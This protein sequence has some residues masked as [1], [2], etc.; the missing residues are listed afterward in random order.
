[1]KTAFLAFIFLPMFQL[2][3]LLLEAFFGQTALGK[4]VAAILL[5]LLFIWCES[6]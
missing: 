4:T 1:M 2:L 6:I 3:A 5:I